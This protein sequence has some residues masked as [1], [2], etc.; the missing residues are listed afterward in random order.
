VITSGGATGADFEWS[1]LAIAHELN[2]TIMTFEGHKRS[3]PDKCNC[4]VLSAA[5]LDTM[6]D[7]LGQVAKKL[8]R[9]LPNPEVPYTLNLLRRNFFIVEDVDVVVAVGYRDRMDV[10]GGTGWGCC[11]HLMF[12]PNPKLF[13]F[14]M[15]VNKWM[16]KTKDDWIEVGAPKIMGYQSCALIGSREMTKEGLLA[17]QD[18]F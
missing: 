16:N 9:A 3:V 5:T 7:R 14:D 6:N 1:K 13:L 2:V 11:Y 4:C 8:N 10:A 17:M 18:V 12:H 15:H